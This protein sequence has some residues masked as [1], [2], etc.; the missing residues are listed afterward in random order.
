MPDLSRAVE[1]LVSAT[2]RSSG[3]GDDDALRSAVDD[4]LGAFESADA[5]TAKAALGALEV[6]TA[7]AEGRGAQVLHLALG[8]LVEGGA[9]P[10]LAWPA[11]SRR[12]RETLDGATRFARACVTEANDPVV[13]DA[14]AS[15]GAAVAKKRPREA[16]AWQ[17]LASRCLAAV[18]CLTR[19]RALR[20][21][22][23][24]KGELAEAVFPLEDAVEEVGFLSQ[25]LRILDD[26]PLL[27]IHPESQRGFRVVVRD[28]SS[29]VELYVLLADAIVGDPAAGLVP[30][31]RPDP[32]A[33]AALKDPDHAP[34]KPPQVMVSFNLSAWTALE[35]DGSLPEAD[36]EH[37]E[38]WIWIEGVPADIP[39]LDGERVVLLHD[40][41]VA[42]M[43]PVESSFAALRPSLVVKKKLS[44]AEVARLLAAMGA[45]AA[46]ARGPAK[47]KKKAPP[48]AKKK[49][50]PAKAKKKGP[51]AKKKA[52]P[53][54]AKKKGP[55]AKKK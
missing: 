1:R 13:D 15:V 25:A 50:A 19:S 17:A 10:E 44:T 4:V 46:R 7:K 26:A 41:A 16:A 51:P 33:V 3:A 39:E 30:G 18:A 45:A 24:A 12:L 37:P 35:D 38:H 9:P 55:P 29:N 47:A 53:A 6:A 40:P 52:A 28:V 2:T 54:K 34:R 20:K 43:L 5:K 23:Q 31:T 49:A 8:A 22:E 27:L 21:A 32:R 42:R 36:A 11:I 48:A 14:I